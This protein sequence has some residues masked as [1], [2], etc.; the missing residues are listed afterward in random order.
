MIRKTPISIAALLILAA[1]SAFSW[2]FFT[3]SDET[4]GGLIAH[5]EESQAGDPDSLIAFDHARMGDY[6]IA[7]AL[8]AGGKLQHLIHASAKIDICQ[9][10]KVQVIPK[11]EGIATKA[12]KN[13]G[14]WVDQGEALAVLESRMMAEAKGSYLQALKK[15]Q[16][17]AQKLVQEKNLHAKNVSSTQE[18]Q[19][20]QNSWEKAA[21]HLDLATQR[22]YALGLDSNEIAKLPLASA[23]LLQEY[24]LHAPLA[25]YVIA[26]NLA[27]GQLADDRQAVY[28]VANLDKL[29]AKIYLFAGDRHLVKIGQDITLKGDSG[30]T[31][32][33]QVTFLSPV[34][35]DGTVTSLAIAEVDNSVGKWLPGSSAKA[36][37][38]FDEY[39]VALKVPK[40]AVQTID[41]DNVLFIM[42]PQ[43]F[44]MRPILIGRS[45]EDD[46]EVIGGLEA[47]EIYAA[48]NTFLLKAEKEKHEAEHMD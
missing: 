4:A 32:S 47:G 44:M 34:V 13:I 46:I 10:Q 27:L 45:D 15:E 9:D 36:S 5:E 24:R 7:T 25:G 38:V 8:A 39:P 37:L 28:T 14:E 2:L 43:G 11:A 23:S 42:H 12:Y 33:V 29:W 30:Q 3:P 17:A 40:T 19:K 6:K 41:G 35:D 22:L 48:T 1:F 16:L 26:R 21:I 20:T 18:Y 31:A